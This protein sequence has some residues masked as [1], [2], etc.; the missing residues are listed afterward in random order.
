LGDGAG[1]GGGSPGGAGGDRDRRSGAAAGAAPGDTLPR[2]DHRQRGAA[3]ADSTAAAAATGTRPA[4][5]RGASFPRRRAAVQPPARGLGRSHWRAAHGGGHAHRL[6]QD[7]LLQPARIAG[8]A[9]GP[10]EGAVPVPDQG[11][12]AGP[13]RRADGT[14]RGRKSRHPRVHLRR[15][16]P[17]G[18]TQG[19]AHQGRHRR[20]EPGHAAPGRAAASHQV[21][22][23]L[24]EPA[25][26][27]DRRD[28]QLPRRVRLA[29]RERDPPPAPRLPFLRFGPGVRAQ[30]RDHRE[31]GGAGRGPDR[32][33]GDRD[34]RERRARR[35][36]ATCCSGTRRW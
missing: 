28:A 30:L 16:H 11:A 25:L 6:G 13:G 36:S 31:P 17:R 22:A 8:G 5:R 12:V 24:R 10:R 32:R 29:R 4:P 23:V 9:R 2:P 15:R 26:R 35:A 33:T 3:R 21:G 7:A 18:R 1:D 27:G 34:H 14:Q 20:L 19:G